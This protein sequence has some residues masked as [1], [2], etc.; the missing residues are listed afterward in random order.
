MALNR[1]S[2]L[3]YTDSAMLKKLS[4]LILLIFPLVCVAQCGLERAI[5]PWQAPVNATVTG[6][7]IFSFYTQD[8]YID[9]STHEFKGFEVYYKV[10]TDPSNFNPALTDANT[11]TS[12]GFTRIN[13]TTDSTSSS[14]VPF[15]ETTNPDIGIIYLV[16]LDF[17]NVAMIGYPRASSSIANFSPL[18]MRRSVFY[19]VGVGY[20][21]S[22]EQHFK[23]FFECNIGDIDIP[24]DFFTAPGDLNLGESR[25]RYVAIY[26]FAYGISLD[27]NTPLQVIRSPLCYLGYDS[28]LLYYNTGL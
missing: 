14:A 10:A 16:N 15:I 5:T 11:L 21:P 28:I 12:N 8:K 26:V 17:T 19:P 24:P 1:P 23:L 6:S 9:D 3:R 22:K 27:S 7:N 18:E 13:R 20:S 2:R 25:L 4:V